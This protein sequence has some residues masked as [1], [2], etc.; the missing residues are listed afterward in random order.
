VKQ[1][2]LLAGAIWKIMRAHK[3][4]RRKR[5]IA[6]AIACASVMPRWPFV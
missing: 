3:A 2:V 4:S 1:T 6:G 5:F